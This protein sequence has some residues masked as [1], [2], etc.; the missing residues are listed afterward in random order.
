MVVT[1]DMP[2][3]MSTF[4]EQRWHEIQEWRD[5]FSGSGLRLPQSVQGKLSY[6]RD[7]ANQAWNAVP[8][9]ETIEEW[10]ARAINGGFHITI[11]IVATTV[12][13]PKVVARV[14]RHAPWEVTG[15]PDF[16]KLD[17]WYLD[18]ACPQ[19]KFRRSL[20]SAGHGAANGFFAGGATMAGAATGGMG[21]LPAAGTVAGLA[22]ADAAAMV[23][24]MLQAS[25][26][27]GAHYGFDPERP[28]EHAILMS[29]LGVA[30]AQEGA[31]TA[32]IMKVR[33]LALM[34]AAG[35]TIAELSKKQLFNILRR[36]Y[37]ALLLKTTKRNI[38]K[39][40][41]LLGIALGVGVNYGSVRRMVD[42][43]QHMYPERFLR[44]K[45]MADSYSGPVK[46]L[47]ALFD[48]AVD[49]EDQGIMDRLEELPEEDFGHDNTE[50]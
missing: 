6:V 9:N 44:E 34:L 39:G 19:L 21:A 29:L 11:D 26:D 49:D 7:R 42:A 36:V 48:E 3:G 18:K 17:L 50:E 40:V 46:D 35:R 22:V 8:G 20:F 14:N 1:G 5:A 43:A 33:E 16:Q 41:P 4:E 31:K 45:Y 28:Q 30:L 32:A 25:A 13:E 27:V 2:A 24:N 23:G 12:R 38:A 15:Y 10:M 37:A 47:D